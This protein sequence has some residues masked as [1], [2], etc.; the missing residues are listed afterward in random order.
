ML[1]V[2]V[3]TDS[4]IAVANINDKDAKTKQLWCPHTSRVKGQSQVYHTKEC[5]TLPQRAKVKFSVGED[6]KYK[7][8]KAV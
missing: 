2:N 6:G 8:K 5:V 3:F 1:A 7:F 4:V